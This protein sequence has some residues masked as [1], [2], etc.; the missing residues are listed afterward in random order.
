MS[1][2]M[3]AT[4]MVRVEAPMRRSPDSVLHAAR[5]RAGRLTPECDQKARS[6]YSSVASRSSADM[7]SSGVNIRYFSSLVRHTRS[8]RPSLSTNT[9]EKSAPP[10]RSG[11]GDQN[12]A[13]KNTAGRSSAGAA[14]AAI[15]RMRP[16]RRN[17]FFI[18]NSS[19]V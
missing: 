7:A 8:T 4:C 9:R 19:V 17:S 6:S 1:P 15:Q 3:R 16:P 2:V 11:R 5:T 12:S 13:K 10:Y 14:A 18:K